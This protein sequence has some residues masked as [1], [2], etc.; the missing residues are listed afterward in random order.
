MIDNHLN[1]ITRTA[2][3]AKQRLR[4][5]PGADIVLNIDRHAGMRFEHF[6]QRHVF[7]IVIKRHSVDNP[8]F[9]INDSGHSD[10]NR[11]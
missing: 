2:G 8:I 1:H 6:A 11:R 3:R 10:R 4:H 9:R 7:H 5:R